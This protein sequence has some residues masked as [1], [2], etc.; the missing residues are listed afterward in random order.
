[1]RPFVRAAHDDAIVDAIVPP[2]N[3]TLVVAPAGLV[4]ELLHATTARTHAKARSRFTITKLALP[5]L[6]RPFLADRH[7][8]GRSSA[9]RVVSEFLAHAIDSTQQ[10]AVALPLRH[11]AVHRRRL[12]HRELFRQSRHREIR[13]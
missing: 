1:M 4:G 11:H 6:L 9:N 7:P 12:E 13:E 2:G 10:I 5:R 8:P 3:T